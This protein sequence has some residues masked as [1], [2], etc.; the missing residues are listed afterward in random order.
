MGVSPPPWQAGRVGHGNRAGEIFGQIGW[1]T[2]VGNRQRACAERTL[3]HKLTNLGKREGN[4]LPGFH[5]RT[6]DT[7]RIR[8]HSAGDIGRDHGHTQRV[9]EFDGG[10]RF[11]PHRFV[12]PNAEN[13]VHQGVTRTAPFRGDL[14][15][16]CKG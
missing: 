10:E 6:E 9:Y 4:G 14:K 11:S 1:N 2:D 7:P 16:I 12:E 15:I 3:S 13:R 5:R 8:F